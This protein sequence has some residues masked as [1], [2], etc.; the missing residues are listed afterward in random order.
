MILRTCWCILA[1]SF[2]GPGAQADTPD[3][4]GPVGID[5]KIAPA[6]KQDFF[7]P[8]SSPPPRPLPLAI[9]EPLPPQYA[10]PMAALLEALATGTTDL[11]FPMR[12][13]LAIMRDAPAVNRADFNESREPPLAE[14]P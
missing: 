5:G 8:D 4:Q 12:I 6:N 14:I 10:P 7:E 2:G 3:M 1:I 11:G 13:A 9:R